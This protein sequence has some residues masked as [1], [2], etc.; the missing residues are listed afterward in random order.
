MEI[1]LFPDCAHTPLCSLICTHRFPENCVT[2]F[3]F[4]AHFCCSLH[5]W[6]SKGMFCSVFCMKLLRNIFVCL[7]SGCVKQRDALSLTVHSYTWS[8]RAQNGELN[9]KSFCIFFFFKCRNVGTGPCLP[10]LYCLCF[11][12]HFSPSPNILVF[13]PP[14]LSFLNE[15]SQHFLR[16][17]LTPI[18]F[19]PHAVT[20]VDS[21][22]FSFF[23]LSFSCLCSL[24]WVVDF[25]FPHTS[26]NLV[27]IP[28]LCPCLCLLLLSSPGALS[29]V[30]LPANAAHSVLRRL[31]R[32]NSMLEELKQG[33]IQRECRD[34]VCTYEE[35][36]EAFENDEKTVRKYVFVFFGSIYSILVFE[37][38][39]KSKFFL[40]NL[41][42][43][44]CRSVSFSDLQSTVT[45]QIW[46]GGKLSSLPISISTKPMESWTF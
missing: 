2:Q 8:Y 46:I 34:E 42:L 38:T 27:S 24:S 39:A 36:R 32:A 1:S 45:S 44:I 28:L 22:L 31:P 19:L 23:C 11:T 21:C 14:S 33:N 6:L 43:R 17:I 7:L 20:L 30:F 18:H 41:S 3:L 4:L 15:L 29:T 25:V 26:F 37:V 16:L 9:Q 5:I 35:A 13:F 12:H 40:G 10:F